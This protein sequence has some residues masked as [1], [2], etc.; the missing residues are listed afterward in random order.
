MRC[1]ILVQ[2]AH[3]EEATPEDANSPCKSGCMACYSLCQT[4]IQSIFASLEELARVGLVKPRYFQSAALQ[5]C[6]CF[7]IDCQ[8]N[9]DSCGAA[10]QT[11]IRIC[12]AAAINLC[13]TC[14][15]TPGTSDQHN[16]MYWGVPS[17][18]CIHNCKAH[19]ACSSFSV[20]TTG[21]TSGG[22]QQQMLALCP[23]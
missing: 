11:R 22:M 13:G 3:K 19:A 12:A 5:F 18:K 8:L 2:A 9:D 23:V 15:S 17:K 1:I 6:L 16:L 10:V 4:S 14:A 20:D 21:H 7:D